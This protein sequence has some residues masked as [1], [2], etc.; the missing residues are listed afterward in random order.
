IQQRA[1]GTPTQYLTGV[2]EFWS[3]EFQVGPEVLIPRPETEHL[4]EAAI[5]RSAHFSPPVIADIGTGSGS[6]AISLQRELPRAAISASDICAHALDVAKRNASRLLPNGSQI[7]FYQGDLFAPLHGLTFDLIV[8][9]PPYVSAADYAALPREIRE[10]EP[11][12]ALY[13]GEDGLDLFRR[14]IT[15]APAFL[16][17]QGYLL[18]E[19]GYGQTQAVVTL[20]QEH[21]LRVHD[22]IQDYAGIDRVVVASKTTR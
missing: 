9:N 10:H 11:K 7:S 3:L 14:L 22:I 2:Q 18:V 13:A 4:V 19:I 1:Q 20:L 6:I 8:S 5:A 17:P 16:T 15:A 21:G 12:S